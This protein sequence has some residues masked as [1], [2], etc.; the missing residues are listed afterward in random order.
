MLKRMFLMG[1]PALL[2]ASGAQSQTLD[3]EVVRGAERLCVYT[4]TP[5]KVGGPAVPVLKVGRGEPCPRTLRRP[6]PAG[7]AVPELAVLDRQLRRGTTVECVYTYLGREYR[8][9]LTSASR[10]NYTPSYP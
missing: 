5:G 9:I 7:E 8:R 3:R 1:L 6:H 4:R 10:C 2:A